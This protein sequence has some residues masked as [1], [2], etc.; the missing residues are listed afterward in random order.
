MNKEQ[1]ITISDRILAAIFLRFFPERVTP[2]HLTIFRFFTVPF[3]VYLIFTEQYIEG[4]ILFTISAFTDALDGALARTRNKITEWGR[5]YDPMADK[6]LI[7]LVAIVL[8]PRFL[9]P[10]IVFFIILIEMALIGSA[11]YL[12]N[13]GQQHRI[14]ANGWGKAKMITQS[15]GVG[16]LLLHPIIAIPNSLVIATYFLYASIVLGVI[17][18]ITYGI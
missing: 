13:R 14:R 9:D 12:K 4:I 6:L 11:Y 1:R 17:S 15:F 10:L 18:L 7:G 2:N 5:M 16:F 3:V 8:V